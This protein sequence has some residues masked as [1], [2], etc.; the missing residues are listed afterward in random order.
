MHILADTPEY[1]FQKQ[2]VKTRGYGNA[3]KGV[4]ATVP[5]KDYGYGLIRDWL[6]SPVVMIETDAEGEE[7]EVTVPRLYTIRNRALLKE[8]IMFN[9]QINVDRIMALLQVM[10]YRQEKMILFQGDPK[11]QSQSASEITNSDYWSKNYPGRKGSV[12]GSKK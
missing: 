1:L 6:L 3:S 4:N 8:L 7:I 10:L 5:V 2:L 12:W 9:P 11:S